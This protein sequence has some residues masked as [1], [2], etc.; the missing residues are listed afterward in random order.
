MRAAPYGQRIVVELIAMLSVSI[1][2]RGIYVPQPTGLFIP[3]W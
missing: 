3:G 2:L 1:E